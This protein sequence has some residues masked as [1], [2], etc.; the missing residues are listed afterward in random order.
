MTTPTGT[1]TISLDFEIEWGVIDKPNVDDYQAELLGVRDVV[2]SL[3]DLFKQYEIH[4]TWATVGLLFFNSREALLQS[5]PAEKPNYENK[6][7]SP[8]NH[9]NRVGAD[10]QDDPLHFAPSLISLIQSYPHQEVGTHTFSHY[11]C[12]E[13]G[14]TDSAFEA[15][16][17]ACIEAAKAY[18]ISLESLVFPRNQYNPTYLNT[19][20]TKG[21]KAYRGNETSWIYAARSRAN[22]RLVRRGLRL[23]DTYINLTSHH[24]YDMDDLRGQAPYN[25][26]SSRF[27]RAYSNK[28]GFLEPL[29]LRRIT[30]GLTHAA[31]HGLGYHLWWHP[32]DFGLNLE[33][34]LAFLKQILDHYASMKQVYGMQ[35]LN[36]GELAQR[37]QNN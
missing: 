4:V 23:V 13:Q 34:N 15:D 10:E 16:L 19:C 17:E 36:M 21:I 12:L 20:S 27:L 28:L 22:E 37:L 11:Y 3:L 9:L 33:K 2:P 31:K 35:S 6:M 25:I 8:Y 14:Q 32:Q 1:F 26:P 5:L 24:C 30:S 7:L 29:R 18:N